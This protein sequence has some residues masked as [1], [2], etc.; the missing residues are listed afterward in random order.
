MNKTCITA[1]ILSILATISC[2]EGIKPIEIAIEAEDFIGDGWAA[3]DKGYLCA[4]TGFWSRGKLV[5]DETDNPASSYKIIDVPEAGLYNLWVHYESCYGFGSLFGI[6]VIQHEQVVFDKKFGSKYERK[7]FPWGRGNIVMGPWYWHNTEMVYEN[8]KMNLEKGEARL[9]IYKDKNEIPAAKRY[10]DFILLT[11]DHSLK[12]GDKDWSHS[13]WNNPDNLLNRFHYPLYLEIKI[14]EGS[15][16]SYIKLI[17]YFHNIGYCGGPKNEYYLS[18]EGL[19]ISKPSPPNYLASGTFSPIMEITLYTMLPS[20][21]HFTA[22]D[23]NGKKINMKGIEIEFSKEKGGKIW[24]KLTLQDSVIPEEEFVYV[25]CGVSLYEKGLLEGDYPQTFEEVLKKQLKIVKDFKPKGIK[26]K[27]FGILGFIGPDSLYSNN[28]YLDLISEMGINGEQYRVSAAIHGKDAPER[29][30]I[31]NKGYITLQNLHLNKDCYEG[32]F[33]EL[34]KRYKKI[35]DDLKARGLWDIPQNI[36]L[37]EEAAAPSLATLRSWPALNLKF[38]E[39]M[40]QQGVEPEEVIPLQELKK[41]VASGKIPIK[42]ELWTMVKLGDGSSTEALFNPKLF[43]YSYS[44]Q[45]EQLFVEVNK[46][47]TELV[48]KYFAPGT[49]TNSGSSYPASGYVAAI[50]N[51]DLFSL[52]KGKA[53]MSTYEG[54]SVTAMDASGIGPQTGSYDGTLSRALSKYHNAFM[55]GVQFACAI[56]GYTPF[57]TKLYSYGLVAQGVKT[58]GFWNFI[59]YGMEDSNI[60]QPQMMKAVKEISY[61]IGDVEDYLIGAKVKTAQVALGWSSSTDIWDAAISPKEIPPLTAGNNIYPMERH[62]LYYALRHNQIPVD[63]LSEEDVIEGYLRNY[64]VYYLVGDHLKKETAAAIKEWV[65]NG[66]IL[67]SVAGGGFLDNFNQPLDTLKEVYGIK[68]E[69]LTK[70]THWMRPKVELVHAKPLDTVI[71]TNPELNGLTLDAYAYKQTFNPTTA[72]V[73]GRY[74]DKKPAVLCNNYGKGKGIII[75]ALP[76]FSYVK[77]AIPLLPFGRSTYSDEELSSFIPT[78][79]SDEVRKI[80]GLPICLA[81]LDRD[82]YVSVPL[83]ETTIIECKDEKTIIIPLINY[84]TKAIS[85][86]KINLHIKGVKSLQSKIHG[87]IEYK[88][89]KDGI[90]LDLPL[91]LVDFL[92]VEKDRLVP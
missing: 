42:D 89:I 6:K 53:V 26:P 4:A 31:K 19:S 49:I 38:R 72:E 24:R 60:S 37:I 40:Q 15:E 82:A 71:F 62:C 16:L 61:T 51:V 67:V 17:S 33:K 23:K 76:G 41:I 27:Q 20:E 28:L 2:A 9:I 13:Q 18:R 55:Q 69:E 70:I 8:G 45:R 39:F 11:T 52:F 59:G 88:Q 22:Y 54:M 57:Y 1:I 86:L 80:L 79:Y 32:N 87:K 5:A 84:S 3:T 34:E 91:E 58:L 74:Q 50:R 44:F 35:A 29:G 78:D 36:K 81:D 48:E 73:W 7:Y 85:S 63:I 25:P 21:L 30:F 92:I 43:Y 90:E 14:P 66:G 75:G 47:A 68:E 64:K 77:P 56:R 83:V 46:K 12:P 65:N 10:I